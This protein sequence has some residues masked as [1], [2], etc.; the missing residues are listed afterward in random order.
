MAAA[1]DCHVLAIERELGRLKTAPRKRAA[2]EQSP[3]PASTPCLPGPP[4]AKATPP[5]FAISPASR[6]LPQTPYAT[7][8]RPNFRPSPSAIAT[9][10]PARF[11]PPAP[12]RTAS[13]SSQADW[14]LEA[15]LMKSVLTQ[16]DSQAAPIPDQPQSTQTEASA[17][18]PPAVPSTAAVASAQRLVQ[19]PPSSSPL[20]NT[21]QSW[22]L[23]PLLL[24]GP[25]DAIAARRRVSQPAVAA[26][27]WATLPPPAPLLHCQQAER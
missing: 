12:P 4:P 10:E 11:S 5:A 18:T 26:D 15:K 8:L 3:T 6:I 16:T 23:V 25:R 21:A 20:I 9:P 13:T 2:Q 22:F 7:Q 19:L 24:W 27:P 17:P 1:V 14:L